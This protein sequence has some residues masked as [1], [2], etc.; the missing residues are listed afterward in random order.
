MLVLDHPEAIDDLAL[1]L[2]VAIVLFVVAAVHR[3]VTVGD[4]PRAFGPILGQ[5][6]LGQVAFQPLEL[7]G[8]Q[9]E[10]IAEKVVDLRGEGDKVHGSQVEAVPQAVRFAGHIEAGAIVGEVAV[11]G[12]C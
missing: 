10:A 11:M 2:A 12:Q 7:L 1:L 3:S 4:D 8:Q 9:L 6:G 5:I